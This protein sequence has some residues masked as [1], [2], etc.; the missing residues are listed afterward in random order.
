ILPFAEDFFLFLFI[1]GLIESP[2][3]RLSDFIFFIGRRNNKGKQLQP[4]DYILRQRSLEGKAT[5][6]G[7]IWLAGSRPS[8]LIPTVSHA[9]ATATESDARTRRTPKASRN[10]IDPVFDFARSALGVRGVLASLSGR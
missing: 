10:L 8:T 5:E 9:E 3:S 7:A 4:E 2:T 1:R 6:G